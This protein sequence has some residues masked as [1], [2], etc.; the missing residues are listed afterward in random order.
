MRKIISRLACLRVLQ[1]E[2]LAQT[3]VSVAVLGALTLAAA[4]LG[5][6]LDKL[7][8]SKASVGRHSK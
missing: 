2:K 3:G 1:A 8:R 5:S 6:V 7:R 4:G